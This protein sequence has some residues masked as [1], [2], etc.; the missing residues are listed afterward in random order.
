MV[1]SE[2]GATGSGM[3]EEVLVKQIG[4]ILQGH[5]TKL[6]LSADGYLLCTKSF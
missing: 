5:K 3:F 4:T 1:D 6:E 2:S